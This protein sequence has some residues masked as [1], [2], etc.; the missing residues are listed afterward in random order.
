MRRLR[1]AVAMSLDGYIAGRNGE[2]D[3]VIM[4]PAI[5]FGAFLARIDTLLMGRGTYEALQAQGPGAGPMAGRDCYV[6]ST[7]LD[8][9]DHPEVTVLSHDIE[10]QV[11][12]LKVDPG[13][14]IWLFGGGVLFRS[15]LELGLVDR[16]EVGVIPI[17]LGGGIP[18]LP[19]VERVAR[20]ELHSVERFPTGVVLMKYDVM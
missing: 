19:G 8:P 16:I 4:D 11:R 6:V 18:L 7:T 15:L 5:D 20:L 10:R 12:S 13:A 9:A 1:Y 14:D 17:L 2:Y 3:W